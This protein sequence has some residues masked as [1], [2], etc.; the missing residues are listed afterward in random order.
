[1]LRALFLLFI[2]VP[3]VEMMV[4]I[5]VGEQIG[6][7]NTVGLVVLTAFIGVAMLR[8]QGLATLLRAN[9]RM[10]E[11]AL[12]AEELLEGIL[13]A[14]GGALLLTPGFVTDAFGFCCLLPFT[15]KMFVKKALS[16]AF[17]MNRFGGSPFHAGA[18]DAGPFSSR[19]HSASG[20]TIE[21]EFRND[22]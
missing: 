6:A 17:V 19:H 12:P 8:Q 1:M 7:L 3:I 20:H 4:L 22:D 21:G 13:L 2:L 5:K 10:S 14:V 16:Q 11:G 18:G 9:Q 15:R